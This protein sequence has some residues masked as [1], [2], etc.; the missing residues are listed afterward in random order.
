MVSV[1]EQQPEISQLFGRT[2]K[3]R[4]L[5]HAYVFEG[6]AGTGKKKMALWIASALFCQQPDTDG[7]PCGE[8]SNCVRIKEH[9]HPDVVELGP[10][11][12]SIKVDQIRNLKAEFSKSG[13]ESNQKVFIIQDAE[14]MTPGAANSLLKF[15]EEPEGDVTAFLLTT[16]KQRLLPTILSRCQDI[17]FSPFSKKKRM[18]ELMEEGVSSS[19]AALLVHL[20]QD[21]DMALSWSQ[22]EWFNS[23]VE[24][25]Q[26]WQS[27]LDRKSP[28]A[29]V[30]VQTDIM[31]TFKERKQQEL[32]LEFML[33]Y[34]RDLLKIHYSGEEDLAFPQRKAELE[35]ASRKLS[36][37]EIAQALTVFLEARK[38]LDS[39]V[40]AQGVF[41]H[42]VLQLL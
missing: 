37:K 10:D 2:L 31:P 27:L 1:L 3:K 30:F 13:V 39:Y 7:S 26:R 21:M 25:I 15:L 6:A 24:T 41:E 36:G 42:A 8:C 18:E 4:Q 23:A 35:A 16:A 38:M 28:Q 40:A 12:N 33:T 17:H 19:K 9:Q 32:A 20:T 34:Y 5:G 11:G 14:K 29:F 22:D